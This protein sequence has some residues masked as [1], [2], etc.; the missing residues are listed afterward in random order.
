MTTIRRLPPALSSNYAWQLRGACRS[1]SPEDFFVSD[2][3]R[4][5]RKLAD[6][7]RAKEVCAGC[8]V[9][10]ECLA[11]AMAVREPYGIWGGTTPDERAAMRRAARAS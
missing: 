5:R 9:V 1:Q 6:E 2:A 3:E 7:A 11:H 8:P 10:P 4:G